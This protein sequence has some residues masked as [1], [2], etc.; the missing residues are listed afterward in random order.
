MEYS[1]EVGE[2]RAL[3]RRGA[4]RGARPREEVRVRVRVTVTVVRVLMLRT[5]SS[6]VF[7]ACF[8][9]TRRLV[10]QPLRDDAIFGRAFGVF[11]CIE[12]AGVRDLWVRHSD[13]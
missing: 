10:S 5:F 8:E 7:L 11:R 4:L 6:C 13:I 12:L 9:K 3:R 1:K 2:G